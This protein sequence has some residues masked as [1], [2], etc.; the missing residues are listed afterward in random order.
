[1]YTYVHILDTTV[2]QPAGLTRIVPLACGA[3]ARE[4]T[5]ACNAFLICKIGFA[6]ILDRFRASA[7][8]APAQEALPRISRHIAIARDT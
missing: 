7:L 4:R 5:Y 2:Q 6:I 3:R 1:M 8:F